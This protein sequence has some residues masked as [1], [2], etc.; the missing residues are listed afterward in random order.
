[1]LCENCGQEWSK[2][3]GTMLFGILSLVQHTKTEAQ[4]K[5]LQFFFLVNI[6]EV[7]SKTDLSERRM[8]GLGFYL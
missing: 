7:K 6:R 5:K 8:E 2:K 3:F 4:R 1:M